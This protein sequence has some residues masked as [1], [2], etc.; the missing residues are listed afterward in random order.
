MTVTIGGRPAINFYAGRSPCCSG[1]DQIDVQV[2]N[3][4]PLGCWVPVVVKAGGVVSNTATMAISSP[5]AKSCDDPGNPLS[6]LVRTPGTQAFIHL[7]QVD[8]IEN[9]ET[10]TPIAKTLGQ[11]YSR[12]YT[13]PDS[14]Y[15]FDPYMSYPPPGSC[16][17]HQISGDAFDAKSLRGTLPASA[18]LSP[19][20]KQTYS[21]GTQSLA[22]TIAATDSSYAN[23]I[24]GAINS[25]PA[26][27]NP[28][29]AGA[30]FTIDPGGANQNVLAINPA[31]PPGWQRP[32]G[33]IV[34]PRN[35]PLAL[36]FTPGDAA[37]P[38]AILLY[39][40]SVGSNSTVEV[41]CLAPPGSGT[42]TISADTL[43]NLPASYRLIDG[44]YAEL[45]LGTLG[46]NKAVAFL[47]L[48]S[49]R[50]AF[51]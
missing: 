29:A 5:G 27:L 20:P 3:D 9:I 48:A 25:K 22:L 16:L 33:I 46:V 15:N 42:F 36:S 17:V 21:N 19:Q 1:I 2:P 45:I 41:Q 23:A 14:P 43:A 4:A 51:C 32:N 49:R 38:T 12:F 40:Y 6:K 7:E 13:R 28:L 24:G 10:S 8:G 34:V 35:A 26:G 37:A 44:S 39:A 31:P 18:S 11:I 47:A 30:S 50:T